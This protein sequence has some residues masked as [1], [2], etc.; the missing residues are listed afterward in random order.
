MENVNKP[1]LLFYQK[2]GELFYA[3]AAAD[4]VVRKTEYDALKNIVT[5]KWKDLD[6]YE[7]PFHTDA[8]YQIEVVF[9]WFDYEQLDANDCFDSFADYKKEN[10]KL[11]TTER[12]KLIWETADAIASSFAGKNKSEL[13]ML[14]KLKMLLKE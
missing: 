3:I 2:M 8:A 10:P 14:A 9:D 11:F 7:D 13:I 12:K 6:D 1:Q 4:N 5:E